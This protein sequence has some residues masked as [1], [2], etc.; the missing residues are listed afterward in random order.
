MMQDRATS[1]KEYSTV[2]REKITKIL[3]SL[4]RVLM[5]LSELET[6]ERVY[7]FLGQSHEA[8]VSLAMKSS[9]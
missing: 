1:Y 6:T 3:L 2:L 5:A 8:G 9:G 7:G 4:M